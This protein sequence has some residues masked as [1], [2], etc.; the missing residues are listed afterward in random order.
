MQEMWVQSLC[1]KD[2][3]EKEMA[4][5]SVFLSGNPMDSRAWHAVVQGVAKESDIAYRL[6]THTHTQL[7]LYCSSWCTFHVYYLCLIAFFPFSMILLCL[8]LNTITYLI[9]FL[10]WVFTFLSLSFSAYFC[11]IAHLSFPQT[12]VCYLIISP[13]PPPSLYGIH[14]FFSVVIAETQLQ[15]EFLWVP[16]LFPWGSFESFLWN[17]CRKVSLY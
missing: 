10:Q 5:H 2:A 15:V 9:T 13:S 4:T 3:L 14:I 7:F 12:L 6:N 11:S 1:Q 8:L 17:L 16:S